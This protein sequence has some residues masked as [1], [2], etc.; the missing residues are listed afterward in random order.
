MHDVMWWWLARCGPMMMPHRSAMDMRICGSCELVYFTLL[1]THLPQMAFFTKKTTYS[2]DAARQCVRA[3]GVMLAMVYWVWAKPSDACD[4]SGYA[5]MVIFLWLKLKFDG[6]LLDETKR[7][8]LFFSSTR[9]RHFDAYARY[10]RWWG[11]R[12]NPLGNING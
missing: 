2:N 8:S 5:Y 6:I 12:L 4:N 7:V 10:S 3:S 11:S 1:L 9:R